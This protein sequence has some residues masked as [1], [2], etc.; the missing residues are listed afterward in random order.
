VSAPEC[1][2][3][4]CHAPSVGRLPRRDNGLTIWSFCA[5]HAKQKYHPRDID[6]RRFVPADKEPE[7]GSGTER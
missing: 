3:V 2:Y 6:M 7:A 5:E 4:G 1:G